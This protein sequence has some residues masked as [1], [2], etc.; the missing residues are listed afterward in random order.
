MSKT[1]ATT[2]IARESGFLYYIKK[3][4]IWCSPMKK[5]GSKA[6]GKAKM[7]APTGVETDYSKSLYYV[8][9]SKSGNLNVQSTPRKNR[10]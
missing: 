4:D 2:D 8:G 5:P 6:K 1:I 7:V 10:K 3:G 9:T